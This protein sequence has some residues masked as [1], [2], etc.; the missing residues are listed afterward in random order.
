MKQLVQPV[1]GTRDFYPEQMAFRNWLYGKIKTISESFGYQEFDGPNLE[2]LSLYSDKTSKEIL[3]KQAF[4]LKDRDGKDL[5]LRPEITP[6]FARM[7]A[8]KAQQLPKEIRWFSFGRA[9]RYEQPQKGRGREF[10]QWEINIL[11]PENPQADSEVIAIAAT[12]LK[13]L[14]FKPEEVSL[15]VNDRQ[16]LEDALLKTGAGK[17]QILPIFRVIDR[18]DKIS[19]E[20]F[21][22]DLTSI[23]LGKNQVEKIEELLNS[24]D[25]SNS[26]W[27]NSLFETLKLY[28]GISEYIEYDPSIIRGFDYY[29]RTVFEAWAKVGSFRALF[30]GGRFDNLTAQIGGE[31]VPGVGFAAGD[32]IIEVFLEE[33]DKKPKLAPQAPQVLVTV[34]N[35]DLLSKSIEIASSLRSK[36]IPTEVWLESEIK[37]DKQLKYADQKGIPYVVILGPEEVEKSQVTLKDLQNKTQSTLTLDEVVS[38]LSS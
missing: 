8:Q 16:S 18:K 4:L 13:E 30:G 26:P 29:T 27:L 7:V 10:F 33:L 34:F 38:K 25:Y 2:Y 21:R 12:Y 28:P 22:Q 31:R 9:W 37:L 24:K 15:K 5:I 11:G 20:E 23:G 6:T 3:E 1:K 36:N 14:G 35:Q 19:K 17:E 32:M